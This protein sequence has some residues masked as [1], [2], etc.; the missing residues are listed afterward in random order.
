MEE[1]G[2]IY[3]TGREGFLEYCVL[4]D[5]NYD[6]NWH[7]QE[8]GDALRQAESWINGNS[9]K[10]KIIILEV[11]PRM[12][13]STEASVLFPG[14]FLGRNP[15]REIITCSYSG[16]LSTEFGRKTRDL[17]NSP[18]YKSIF[19]NLQLKEDSQSKS[20]W[21]TKEGGG[22]VSVGIGGTLTGQGAD[23]LLIDDPHANREEANSKLQREKVWEWFRSTAMSRLEPTGVVVLIM[24]RWHKEDLV[25]KIKAEF[26]N[27]PN[28]EIVD[29]KFPAQA[30][31]DEKYRKK[32]EWLWPARFPGERMESIKKIVGDIAWNSQYQQEPVNP[33]DQE[34]RQ[35]WFKYEDKLPQIREFT[36]TIDLATGDEEVRNGDDNVICVV[37]KGIG[38]EWHIAEMIGGK[39]NP[40]ELCDHVLR[41]YKQYLPSTIL[42]EKNGYQQTFEFWLN[43]ESRKH[44]VNLPIETVAHSKSKNARIR[45]LL[46]L[47]RLGLIKSKP[48]LKLESQL[49]DFPQGDHDDWADCLAMQLEIISNTFIA[50]RS[51]EVQGVFDPYS[52][53]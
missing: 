21:G 52:V 11:P 18:A 41:L 50:N 32:G 29:I 48:I 25:G 27:D 12:G 47:Y 2:Q 24:Q 44:Q 7:H 10:I 36:M 6:I 45:G 31:R 22:Y 43:E 17:V 46:P 33:E 39:F 9:S 15:E 49:L 16:E 4:A 30:V 42:I 53:C 37:G 13:K 5:K 28:I 40:L 38:P 51:P 34:F 14:W 1:L 8:I 26:S 23:L 3:A 20:R 35:E 19:P